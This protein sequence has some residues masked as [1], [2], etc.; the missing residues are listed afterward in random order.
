MAKVYFF[1]FELVPDTKTG[2]S[3][4]TKKL[5]IIEKSENFVK[6]LSLKFPERN[7]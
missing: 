3:G 4:I 1:F 2:S 7:Y 6:Y 5:K